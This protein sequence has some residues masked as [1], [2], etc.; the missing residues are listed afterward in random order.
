MP[1]TNGYATLNQIKAA[2]RIVDAIDDTLLEMAIESAS[3]LIDGHTGRTF[4]SGG[5]ATRVFAADNDFVCQIDDLQNDDIVLETAEN[6]D[7]IFDTTWSTT[8]YQLEPLNKTLD[9]QGWVFTRIRAVGDY[10]WPVYGQEALVRVTGAWGWPEVPNPIT[11]ATIIQ[12]SR[13]F[14]RLDSPL[15]VAGFG[16]LGVMR[17]SRDIDPDVAQLVSTYKRMQVFA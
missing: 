13:I 15:G 2:L 10:L 5:T 3:R 6:A 7:G 1:I 16:D 14:K 4:Y 12:A 11:Q 9:G 8:D 17:V